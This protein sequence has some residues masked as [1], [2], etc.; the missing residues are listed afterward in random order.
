MNADGSDQRQL[1]HTSGEV[2][3][4]PVSW[5]PDDTRIVFN[6]D[7]VE[8]YVMDA[9]GGNVHRLTRSTDSGGHSRAL[10]WG[11]DGILFTSRPDSSSEDTRWFVMDPDGTNIRIWGPS[12]HGKECPPGS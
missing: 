8:V 3:I 10:R 2:T 4:E 6:R 12:G 1:T 7:Y 11:A 5:S 9:D